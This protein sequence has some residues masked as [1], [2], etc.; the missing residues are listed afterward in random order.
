MLGRFDGGLVVDQSLLDGVAIVV[1]SPDGHLQRVDDP[2]V[3]PYWS[4]PPSRRWPGSRRRSM[5]ATSTMP[6]QVATSVK[7]AAQIRLGAAR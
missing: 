5:K 2:V 3:R 7:S 4:R 1:A 6:A